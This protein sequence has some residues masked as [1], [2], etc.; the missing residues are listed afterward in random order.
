[1]VRKTS[2]VLGRDFRRLRAA[3]MPLSKGMEISSR[4][5]SGSRFRAASRRASPSSTVPA[6]SNSGSRILLRPSV[7]S[8]WSSASRMR[9]RFN[10][11]L[12]HGHPDEDLGAAS[13]NRLYGECAVHEANSFLHTDDAEPDPLIPGGFGVEAHAKVLDGELNSLPGPYQSDR[14]PPGARVF[15]YIAKSFLRHAIDAGGNSRRERRRDSSC[16]KTNVDL[17][18]PGKILDIR[19]HRNREAQVV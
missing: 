14:A 5:T 7:T 11:L 8:V 10:F 15:G 9:G 6:S 17:F 12:L 4:I 3:S 18:P 1:M 16:S 13:G 2:L 19:F